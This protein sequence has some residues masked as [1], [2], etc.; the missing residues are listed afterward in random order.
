MCGTVIQRKG[1]RD[2]DRCET[3]ESGSS[4]GDLSVWPLDAGLHHVAGHQF[5]SLLQMFGK[6][7][8]RPMEVQHE[9][10]QSIQLPEQILRGGRAIT[11]ARTQGVTDWISQIWQ[12]DTL[13]NGHN[14]LDTNVRISWI[15]SFF[16]GVVELCRLL[17][18]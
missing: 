16:P 12:Q 6:L 14:Y 4:C 5:E 2:P 9:H 11:A 13:L 10:L 7:R 17:T 1:E 3:K 15:P 18:G 8:L